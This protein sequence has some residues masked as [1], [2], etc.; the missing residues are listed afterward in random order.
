VANASLRIGQRELLGALVLEPCGILD[1]S[2]YGGL[3]DAMAKAGTEEPRAVIVDVDGLDVRDRSALSVFPAVA[4]R[5]GQWPG[6]PVLLASS[7]EEV[8]ELLA[9]YRLDRFVPVH[10]SVAAAAGAIDDPPPR[11]VQRRELPNSL[12]SAV[13]ARRFVQDTCDAWQMAEPPRDDAVDIVNELVENTLQH[14]YCAP[15]IRLELRRGVFT[16]AVYDDDPVRPCPGEGST[17]TRGKRGLT[18]V[19]VLSR[20]WGCSP[21]PWGGKVVWAV[22]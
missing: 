16:V 15:S 5:L 6:V 20:V 13:R 7:T 10:R 4:E 3:R 8:H 19:D 9:E 17:A 1:A 11:L 14:T 2:S 21:T 22:L 12:A 18:L